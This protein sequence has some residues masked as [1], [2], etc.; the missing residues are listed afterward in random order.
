MP[1]D[2]PTQRARSA[3]RAR[4]K[5]ASLT[6]LEVRRR[7]V[8]EALAGEVDLEFWNAG[9]SGSVEATAGRPGRHRGRRRLR[10]AGAR[11][12]STTTVASSRGRRRSSRCPSCAGPR[13]G[14]HRARRRA[15]RL[16]PGRP[17]PAADAV[18]AAGAAPDR[19]RGRRRGA[20]AAHRARRRPTC[21]SATWCGS[22]TPSPASSF[23]HT[24]TVQLLDG[25]RVRRPGR[26][27]PRPRAWPSD[28]AL[29]A[30][31][32]RS[33]RQARTVRMQTAPENDVAKP[34]LASTFT[35]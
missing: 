17:R 24:R 6:Q 12:C 5:Q 18:A 2:V 10:A 9:G 3:G 7:E 13:P 19:A 22:G 32:P 8:A 35:R 30:G 16:R 27:L 15:G 34:S 28:Q 14:R 23:E 1:D 26:D 20:D 25:R 31:E 29:A 11:R 33:A 21:G 4:L